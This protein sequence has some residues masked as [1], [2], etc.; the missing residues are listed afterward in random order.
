MS[1]RPR[2]NANRRLS[3]Q[4]HREPRRS[5]VVAGAS[6]DPGKREWTPWCWD[7]RK[8]VTL[9]NETRRGTA[10]QAATTLRYRVYESLEKASR[11]AA[12]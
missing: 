7:G 12:A 11:K 4:S 5:D 3:G 2:I 10:L 8:L 9:P 1:R 6:W